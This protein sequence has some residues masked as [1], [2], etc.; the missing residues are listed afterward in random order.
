MIACDLGLLADHAHVD[1]SGKLYILGEF[2]Y[3]YAPELPAR[4]GHFSVVA[5]WTADLVEVRDRENTI[6]LE[7]V[8]EDG[9][10][11][12]PRSKKLPLAF[13]PIGPAERGRA[14]AQ[15]VIAMDGF[16][17]TK[18]GDHVIHFI[19]NGTHN[20]RVRFHV[21][22]PKPPAGETGQSRTGS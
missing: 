1:P 11:V 10:P 2:R 12:V 16:V 6:E 15:A 3:I 21:L 4:H 5:R 17:L 19:V 18:Y 9:N 8:D 20:G 7:I 13:G 22:R 14:H